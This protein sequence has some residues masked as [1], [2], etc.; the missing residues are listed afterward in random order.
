M[1]GEI[2]TV[3]PGV[4]FEGE[5]GIRIEDTVMLTEKGIIRLFTDGK[6]LI[7]INK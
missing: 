5:Y 6:E 1:D 7:E 3:E 4:Y 2:F